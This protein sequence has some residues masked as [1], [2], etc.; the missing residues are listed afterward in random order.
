MVLVAIGS[1][2]DDIDREAVGNG[3]DIGGRGW[4]P[5]RRE[6]RSRI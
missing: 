5:R 4:R 6:R 2:D 1:A 3:D